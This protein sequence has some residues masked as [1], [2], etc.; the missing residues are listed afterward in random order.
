MA[1]AWFSCSCSKVFAYRAWLQAGFC[2][3]LCIAARMALAMVC[4]CRDGSG[5]AVHGCMHG[6]GRAGHGCW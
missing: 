1:S 6:F 3:I 5:L 4:G 2:V